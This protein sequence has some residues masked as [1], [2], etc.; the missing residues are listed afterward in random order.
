MNSTNRRTF[1]KQLTVG[2]AVAAGVSILPA[3]AS[4]EGASD[5]AMG[6]L[7]DT[8]VCVGCRSCEWACKTA[9]G[10]PAGDIEDFHDRSVF[11]EFRRPDHTSY[12]VI[13]EFPAEG[14]AKLPLNVKYQCM[15]C[16]EP[17]CAS[18]CIVGAFTKH[19]TGAVTWDGSMC[20]GC[21]YCMVA[22]PFQIPTF[23]YEKA[24][25]P[26]IT[27]CDFCYDR[28]KEG[29]LPACVESCPVEVMVYGPREDL[30]AIARERIK[31]YPDR[32]IDRIFG[33]KVVGGTSWMYLAPVEFDKLKFPPLGVKPAPGVTEA[34]QHGIFAYFI[35]PLALFSWLG[36]VMWLTKRK[37]A[38]LKEVEKMEE[39]ENE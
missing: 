19:E 13:N 29:K 34:I 9:H 25:Q 17:A 11:K 3:K 23:E 8:A 18:A 37:E 1:L 22:C 7:V 10:I 5:Q 15:H 30:I 20:I 6:V 39:K 4:E 31:R 27:K 36:G 24:I 28:T 2:S 16:I 14:S 32:Y 35:P 21:R 12:C 26:N 33:E 38:I